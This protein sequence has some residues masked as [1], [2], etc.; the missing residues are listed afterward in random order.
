MGIDT[1]IKKAVNKTVNSGK[2]IL[3]NFKFEYLEY[4][5]KLKS[6]DVDKWAHWI[7][8]EYISNRADYVINIAYRSRLIIQH[9]FD[10]TYRASTVAAPTDVDGAAISKINTNDLGPDI[11]DEAQNEVWTLM[12]ND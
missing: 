9:H 5:D 10:S 6:L 4:N 7:Y 2:S 11:F 12:A 8:D 1:G 3:K